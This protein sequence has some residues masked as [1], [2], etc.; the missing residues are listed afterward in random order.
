MRE[1]WNEPLTDWIIHDDE[2]NRNCVCR[3]SKQG[4]D[5]RRICQ[6]NVWRQPYQLRDMLLDSVRIGACISKLDLN[7]PPF[8]P[9]RVAHAQAKR[10]DTRFRFG[11]IFGDP[12]QYAYPPHPCGLRR[13]NR[14]RPAPHCTANKRDELAP[15]HVPPLAKTTLKWTKPSTLRLLQCVTK[16]A[17]RR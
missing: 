11:I 3:W 14:E 8:D 7:I 9:T 4:H 15:P 2:D 12:K 17:G 13:A 5:R 1:I 16:G 10:S 6:D